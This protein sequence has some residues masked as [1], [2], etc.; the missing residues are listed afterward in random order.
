[1]KATNAALFPLTL[2]DI[3]SDCLSRYRACRSYV[4]RT[5][6][7]VLL[8]AYLFEMRELLAQNREEY[9]LSR[10]AIRA[11]L[12]RGG[13]L[14]KTWMCSSSVSIAT[15][16][17]PCLSQHSAIKRLVSACTS[18]VKTRRRYLVSPPDDR[19]LNSGYIW[20]YPLANHFLACYHPTR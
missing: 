17:N 1:M 5:G 12:K 11:G 4:I 10:L 6:P 7:E 8:S 2:H 15:S 18:P 19:R 14:T 16:V 3:P 13:A 20:F 9:P